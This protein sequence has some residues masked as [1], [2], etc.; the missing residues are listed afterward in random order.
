MSDV[1]EYI[2]LRD[3]Y[4]I[5]SNSPLYEIEPNDNLDIINNYHKTFD[6]FV[7][8][9]LMYN[10]LLH[11]RIPN[12]NKYIIIAIPNLRN[13]YF[14]NRTFLEPHEQREIR[15]IISHHPYAIMKNIYELPGLR[16]KEYRYPLFQ[17]RGTLTSYDL[18]SIPL[19]YYIEQIENNE[20]LVIQLG[21][22]ILTIILMH[23][24][25]DFYDPVEEIVTSRTRALS[26]S[27]S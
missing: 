5:L 4:V 22:T 19:D 18:I 20:P 1:S 3:T 8:G 9:N 10:L 2:W 26:R 16:K 21:D 15:N 13:L 27:R 17:L 24:P 25:Y 14:Q 11:Q 23:R 7:P 6:F 12:E